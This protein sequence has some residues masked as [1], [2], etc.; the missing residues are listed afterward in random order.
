MTDRSLRT[1]LRRRA[2]VDSRG[3]AAFRVALGLVLLVDLAWRLPE[4]RAH[5]T[6]AGA[7]PRSV[8]GALYPGWDALSLHALSGA[9]WAQAALFGLAAVAAAALVVGYRTRLATAASL[10]LLVSLQ[11]RNPFVLNGGDI[12]LRRLLFWGLFLPLGA[13]WA[14][15]APSAR[16]GADGDARAPTDTVAG[17]ATV[18]LL[19]QVVAVYVTN[20]AVKLRADIWL[21]GDAVRHVFQLDQFTV[22]LGD[23]LAGTG[24][25]LSVAGWLWLGL[26]LVSPLLLLLTGRRRGLLAAAFVVAHFGML[27]TLQIGVFPLVSMTALLPFLPSALWDR[28]ERRAE[29]WDGPALPSSPREPLA[30]RLPALSTAARSLAAVCLA[31]LIVVNAVALGVVA[32]PA[33]TPERVES[34]SWDMF[35]PSPPLGTWWY[36]APA[37]LA[38]GERVN[39]LT[40]HDP[41]GSKPP[42]VSS[43]Y[44]E[45]WRKLLGDAAGE[46]LLR[47]SLADSL[48]A[49]WNARHSDDAVNVTLVRYREPTVF[50]GPESI[51]REP[52]GRYQCGS[53]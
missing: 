25:L 17:V 35:A 42:E 31:V 38:S 8:L 40:D 43:L 49:R 18:G 19:A 11:I 30:A 21:A 51:E 7:L 24:L 28:V 26:L 46:P 45:R 20:A 9:L 1:W 52:L 48:C 44:D 37:T 2:A 6:D 29:A 23:V 32:A 22:L 47:Q 5:Y 41:D 10:V 4:L 14:V 33:G 34:R 50:D 27:L 12:L 36:A 53:D 39:L 15:D 13:R 3:L 16:D